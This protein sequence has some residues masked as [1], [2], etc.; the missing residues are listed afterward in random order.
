MQDI[1]K[2]VQSLELKKKAL[3]DEIE[4]QRQLLDEELKKHKEQIQNEQKLLQQEKEHIVDQQL[5]TSRYYVKHETLPEQKSKTGR[6]RTLLYNFYYDFNIRIRFYAWRN[7][8]WKT[9]IT[10]TMFYFGM[11]INHFRLTKKEGILLTVVEN[12]F[13]TFSIGYAQTK[14]FT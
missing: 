3:Q 12:Y 8:F 2:E 5:R 13:R 4:K 10:S 6:W 1:T 7:V 9:Q 14:R 11:Q